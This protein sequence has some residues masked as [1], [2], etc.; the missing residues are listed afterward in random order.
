MVWEVH[1]GTFYIPYTS[2][3][4]GYK[5]TTAWSEELHKS[6]IL[7][8]HDKPIYRPVV[9]AMKGGGFGAYMYFV[10]HSTREIESA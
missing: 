5:Y 6:I 8:Y 7:M 9:V 4:E 2:Y 1:F 3:N 10:V